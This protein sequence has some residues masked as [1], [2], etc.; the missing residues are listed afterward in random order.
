MIGVVLLYHR[1]NRLEPDPWNL[2]V[3]PENFV[4]Q[5]K[6]L[7][8]F[9]DVQ[10]LSRTLACVSQDGHCYRALSSIT[11]DDG[12]ADNLELALPML[13]AEGLPATIFVSSG[14]LDSRRELWSDAL[15]RIFLQPL[16]LP[17]A[18][19]LRVDGH[20]LRVD[21]S[22][23]ESYSRHP[24]W[25]WDDDDVTIRHTAYRTLFQ[26]IRPLSSFD[27]KEI[28][29]NLE[30]WSQSH[31]SR[32]ERRFLTTE[33]VRTLAASR[34]IE[35]GAHTVTH[36]VLSTLSIKS[37]QVEIAQ[38]KRTLEEICG[39]PVNAFAYPNGGAADYTQKTVSLVREAGFHHACS[40]FGGLLTPTI[41]RYQI[42][43]MMVRN[44][45]GHT[46]ARMLQR[47]LQQR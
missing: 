32:P 1:V 2:S 21:F 25:D 38:S 28:I 19:E 7:R 6:V 40:A 5:L 3:T 20:M 16:R 12:Y 29:H 15:D 11:F 41:D 4:E 47:T 36:P 14:Y 37:Q 23:C 8:A 17:S 26:A 42:P 24:A 30:H 39:R 22:G 35:I 27:Q 18:L 45:D 43:R 33:E 10:P 9:T 34:L 13:E 44:W 31:N 46:F